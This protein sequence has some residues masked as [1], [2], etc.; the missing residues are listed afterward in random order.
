MI[1]IRNDGDLIAATNYWQTPYAAK[2][3]AYLSINAGAFRLLLPPA[4][5][6]SL[7]EMAGARSVI[8]SRGPWS[9]AGQAE[10][11]EVLFEDDGPSPFVML[12]G[13]GQCDRF[14]PEKD[15]G[16]ED[17]ECTVWTEEAK[18]RLRFPA[19]YRIVRKIPC[20]APWK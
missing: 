11:V 9:E 8:V 1:E 15:S 13:K 18:M 20:L 17:L 14:P 10:A 19:R 12:L 2:G 16:R 6:S 4:M 3:M 5:E 7:K